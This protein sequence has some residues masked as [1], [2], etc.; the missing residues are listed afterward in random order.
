[1]S[2]LF[3][4]FNITS[5]YLKALITIV[6]S[7]AIAKIFDI[8]VSRF[9]KRITK[10]TESDV[11]D[12]IVDFIHKPLFLTAL[13]IGINLSVS[14][15]EVSEKFVFRASAMLYSFIVII[16]F[17]AL[18]KVSS[19]VIQAQI[20]KESDST[21]L[22]KDII[23]FAENISRIILFAAALMALLSLWKINIT[24]LVASAGIAGAA[25]AFAAKDMLGNFFGGISIFI[26]KPFKIGDFIILDQGERGEVVTIGIRSTR[27]RTMDDMLITVPNAIL[28]NTK[29]INESAPEPKF[30]I[31]VPISV[32]YGSDIDL[33][34]KILLNAASENSNIE[35]EPEPRVRFRVFGDSGLNFELLCWVREPSLR[36]LTVHQLNS[37]IYKSFNASNIKIPFPQRDVHIYKEEA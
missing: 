10:Y 33:V 21:G 22:K 27:I 20:Q 4:S 23:P 32:A 25:V 13:F 7:V 9:L 28:A 36:G 14:Y 18:I 15:L 12:R 34:E 11:D 1:M 35:K 29:I 24:P 16:W 30:R 37:G 5:S 2:E 19:L 6:A 17:F 8:F 26:D 3:D 31:K